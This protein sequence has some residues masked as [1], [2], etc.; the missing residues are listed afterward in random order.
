MKTVA[1]IQARMSS[2]RLSGKVLADIVGKALIDRIISRVRAARG[3]DE[4]VVATTLEP[5]DD[6]L[7]R[8]LTS[9]SRCRVFRGSLDDVLERFYQCASASQADV[10]VRITAD[11]PLK[12]PLIIQRAIELLH[13]DQGLDY[14]SNTI[15]PTYPEGLDVEVFRFSALEAAHRQ[16][17][18]K[19]EREHVTPFI[20]KRPEQFRIANFKYE[21]DLSQW[22]WTVDHPND[23]EFMRRVYEHF[24]G[25]ELVSYTDVIAWLE[26]S[27]QI[28]AINADAVRNEGY[29]KSLASE[30][31]T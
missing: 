5:D 14:V 15:E 31:K 1:I 16:A 18:L 30:Q 22:R 27:P 24:Q 12:D 3:I 6:V 9:N 11:D 4:V 10:I 28:R 20:W 23:L 8:H 19:S 29:L 7:V 2:V 21:R 26:T 25:A 13:A 17:K